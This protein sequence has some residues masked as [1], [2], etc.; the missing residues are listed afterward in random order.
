MPKSQRWPSPTPDALRAVADVLLAGGVAVIPTDTVYGL[1]AHP[2]FPAAVRRIYEIKGRD[3]GKPIALLASDADAPLRLGAAMPPAARALAERFW[4]GAL[5][6][7][8]DTPA[9]TEGFR[10]PD[11]PAARSIIAMCGGLLRVTSANFS[12]EPAPR[13]F[14]AIPA[15]FLDLCDASINAGPCPGGVPSAVVKFDAAGAATLLRPGPRAL[16]EFLATNSV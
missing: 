14:D 9:A 5:T 6:L 10:V 12:G 7:V 15:S 16:S 2:S 8:L 13:D 4:P 3:E 11:S 1:A